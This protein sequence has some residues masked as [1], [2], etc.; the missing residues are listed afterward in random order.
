MDNYCYLID[1]V[2]KKLVITTSQVEE[3]EREKKIGSLEVN[4]QSDVE[5]SI[6]TTNDAALDSVFTFKLSETLVSGYSAAICK[7]LE[8][9][10]SNQPA[11]GVSMKSEM[12][13]NKFREI[14]SKQKRMKE[15]KKGG[16]YVA[17]NEKTFGLKWQCKIDPSTGIPNH[18]LASNTFHYVGLLNTLESLFK[19]EDLRTTYMEYNLEKKH[20][21]VENVYVDYCCGINAKNCELFEDS[22][23]IM[24][25]IGT[26][27][28]EVC[29]RLQSKT[30]K[31]NVKGL[32]FR[33][34]NLPPEYNSRLS[35]IHLV[36]LCKVQ[37]IKQ[38]GSSFDDIAQLFIDEIHTL[39]TVGLDIGGGIKLKG[40]LINIAADNLE[41]IGLFGFVKCF[42]T[43]GFC[44]ICECS[45]RQ[46][47]KLVKEDTRSMRT[48]ESCANCLELTH[49]ENTKRSKGKTHY[50][51]FNDLKYFHIL[52]NFRIDIMHDVGRRSPCIY[53]ILFR[54]IVQSEDLK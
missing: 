42:N 9:N 52:E 29:S 45:K 40:V 53:A 18:F 17:A 20:K 2:D 23:K 11:T 33:V 21:C 15:A 35:N 13:C 48:K 51:L 16:H 49:E 3:K 5:Y 44:R 28:F 27:D 34:R 10:D 19:R 41:A 46:S 24:L 47:E 22:K 12:F 31:H 4:I 26:D 36:A 43:D 37:D 54:Y 25:E 30:V 6:Q 14:N 8:D 50:C 1:E 7:S 38:T 32:Y 39:E